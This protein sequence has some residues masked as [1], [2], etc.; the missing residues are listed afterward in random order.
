VMAIAV[1]TFFHGGVSKNKEATTPIIVTF[2]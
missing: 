1:I 2:F